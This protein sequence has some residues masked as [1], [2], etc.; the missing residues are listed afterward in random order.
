MRRGIFVAPFD[1]L[2]DPRLLAELAA[3]AEERGFDGV[4][5]LGPHPVLRAASRAGVRP[6]G[7]AQRDRLRDER[8]SSSARWS[9][10]SRA[11]AIQKLARETVTLDRPQRRPADPRRRAWAA[12]TTASSPTSTRSS[13]PRERAKLLDDGPRAADRVL[14]R[15]VR[16]AARAASRA[17]RSGS[18]RA[19]PARRPVRR[20]ARWDG[21]FPI[22]LPGPDA[23]AELVGR[24]REQ[25]G[26]DAGR[27]TS[28][29]PSRRAPTPARGRRRARRGCSP[30]STPGPPQPRSAP[31]STPA[32]ASSRP[33]ST[34]TAAT[35]RCAGGTCAS[36]RGSRCAG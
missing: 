34:G 10:R 8:G 5:P 30:G 3:E 19:G 28:S 27:S 13:E 17:S 32:P 35:S 29:S 36:G 18:P 2:S 25:R 26:D 12:T 9:R 7:R 22:E 16:A 23:L 31:R 33:G 24:G 21:L 11:G 6:V 14:G 1:E 20:A 4:L 15:R